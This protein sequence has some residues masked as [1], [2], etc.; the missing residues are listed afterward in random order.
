MYNSSKAA[1]NMAVR[2]LGLEEASKGVRVNCIMPGGMVTDMM[3]Q[4]CKL[5]E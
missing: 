5:D 4:F 3:K 1:L 2:I